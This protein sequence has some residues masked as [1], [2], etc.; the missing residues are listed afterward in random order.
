MKFS[1]KL[2]YI[3]MCL[4]IAVLTV[5]G[6]GVFTLGKPPMTHW[7]LMIHMMAAPVFALGLAAVAL[8]W[9][10]LCRK[11]STPHLGAAAKILFWIILV[12]GLVVILT[13]VV[14][15]L[16]IFGTDGQHLLYLTHRYAGIVLA[17]AVLMH[18]PALRPRP[19]S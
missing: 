14:P 18:F 11:G 7:V 3:V 10:D 2:A 9:A 12:C 4:G 16:P 17:V 13:G 19:L 1:A 8:T 15:M 5:T 6:I